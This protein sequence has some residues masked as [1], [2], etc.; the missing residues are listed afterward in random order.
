M[1]KLKAGLLERSGY[2]R[3]GII[4]QCG[5][6]MGLYFKVKRW[7]TTSGFGLR[8]TNRKY[9]A[10]TNLQRVGVG[11]FPWLLISSVFEKR[12]VSLLES[13]EKTQ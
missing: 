2:W 8:T 7:T 11:I 3:G 12:E 9:L 5:D 10:L 6:R 4:F 1:L 13:P